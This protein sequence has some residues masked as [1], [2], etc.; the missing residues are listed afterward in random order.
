[1]MYGLDLLGV[2][3]YAK[4]A[5]QEFPTGFAL[6]AFSSTFGGSRRAVKAIV[7]SGKCPRVRIQLAWKDN[8]KFTT[9]DFPSIRREALK[10]KN[11][12]NKYSNVQWFFS[13]ACEHKM[14]VKDA[15]LLAK[16][17][18]EALPGTAYVNSIMKGGA[19][20]DGTKYVNEVHGDKA[21][22]VRGEWAFSFDG[23]AC[24]DAEVTKLKRTLGSCNTFFFWDSRFNGKWEDS[25]TT[26]RPERKG[27]PGTKLIRSI[28]A[29]AK[30]EGSTALPPKWL[31][32]SHAEN[33]GKKDPRAE[34]PVFIV[35]VKFKSLELRG[36]N[37]VKAVF[38]YYK[39]FEGGGYRYYYSKQLGYEISDQILE[40][41]ADGK[42]YGVINPAFRKGSYR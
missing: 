39:P 9:R 6:G 14:N 1:M 35:P 26:P 15:T 29:L 37:G 22:P 31:Y 25:D 18:Q 5:L 7:A 8:H 41:W 16:I 12:V 17:V 40:V 10:W 30:D 28:I 34:K 42:K 33:K 38:R 20:I 23:K 36:E 13:G 24:V 3:K 4:V 19:L 11:L 21:K 27:W 32:K 2:A